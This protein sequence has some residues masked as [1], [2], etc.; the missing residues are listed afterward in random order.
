MFAQEVVPQVGGWGLGGGP[1]SLAAL[2][3]A[4]LGPWHLGAG[5]MTRC[6]QGPRLPRVLGRLARATWGQGGVGFRA[7]GWSIP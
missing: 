3:E 4:G 6:R 5:R 7:R 2:G 1:S